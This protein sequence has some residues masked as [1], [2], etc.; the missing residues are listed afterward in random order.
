MG[1]WFWGVLGLMLILSGCGSTASYDYQIKYGYQRSP[2]D[3]SDPAYGRVPPEWY[4]NDPS[5]RQ[6]YTFP[7]IN[8][9]NQ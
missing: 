6:W 1:A 4:G 7:Y 9:E 5:M 8:P 3:P 2:Y